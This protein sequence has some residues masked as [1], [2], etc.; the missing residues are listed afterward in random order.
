VVSRKVNGVRCEWWL[1]AISIAASTLLMLPVLIA[2]HYGLFSDAGQLIEFPRQV[3]SDWPQ[4]I[5]LFK[6]LPDGR[7]NPLFHGLSVAL[8]VISPENPLV[9]F[10][11]QHF[12]LSVILFG[13]SYMTLVLTDRLL[14]AIS[15]VFV[16]SI[17]SSLFENFFTLDKVEPRVSFFLIIS[18]V[19]LWLILNQRV[20]V[21]YLAATAMM[22][23]MM[24]FSKETGVFMV[25]SMAVMAAASFVLPAFKAFRLRLC[26]VFVSYL[27]PFLAYYALFKYLSVDV[28]YRYV[29]YDKSISLVLQNASFYMK[30]SP[31]LA[32]GAVSAAL[33][34][35]LRLW[36]SREPASPP[37]VMMAALS[38]SLF[39][40][41]SGILLWR[42]PLEYYLLPAHVISSIILP[43][44][45]CGIAG[46][47]RPGK[48]WKIV[49]VAITAS[50]WLTAMS[51][52]GA[53]AVA[54]YSFDEAKDKLAVLLSR[55]EFRDRRLIVPF[56]QPD[57]AE[58][59]ERLQFFIDRAR[60]DSSPVELF[61]MW[62]PP[63]DKLLNLNRF[64][65]SAGLT[66]TE[67]Q[68]RRVSEIPDRTVIWKFGT[69]GR[70]TTMEQIEGGPESANSMWRYSTLQKGDLLLVPTGSRALRRFSARGLAAHMKTIEDFQLS[71]PVATNV[72]A[73]VSTGIGP[74]KI[75]WNI[76]EV[77]ED[78]AQSDQQRQLVAKL[79]RLNRQDDLTDDEKRN[80][81]FKKQMLPPDSVFFGD[82]W[83]EPEVSTHE[84]FRWMG[85]QASLWITPS[86][87]GICKF[88]MMVEPLVTS[89]GDKL[90]LAAK[91]GVVT[92]DVIQD[93][94]EVSV[95]I[96]AVAAQTTEIR[97]SA[98]GG[99]EAPPPGD[100][101][102]LKL[103]VFA[104]G[105]LNCSR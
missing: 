30:T 95:S 10:I 39:A 19:F 65:G 55:P 35:A 24:I 105:T 70:D 90:T 2:P 101:R 3:V 67:G 62:E 15:S 94:T 21:M 54:I 29:S 80:A 61:N 78:E 34:L 64:E 14:F 11:F 1:L 89:A 92:P 45:V 86:S 87:S 100:T 22:S 84:M 38:M 79:R 99:L 4:S 28:D 69:D 104:V 98:V 9:F 43:V 16:F 77:T 74:I 47:W 27:I 85:A 88:S 82:G 26:L 13:I 18:L 48:A 91:E 76:L 57:S 66:P 53:A 52:R 31:E 7:W 71:T 46:Q 59:G 63:S 68:L 8:Y 6:P 41:I 93:R 40:Y 51:Q 44:V 50:L 75:A 25:A 103:R 20:R 58:F 17:S 102:L 60:H 97:L 56:E 36:K 83:Y 23:A 37:E 81:F 72:L 32:I 96:D 33:I 12:M 73:T 49:L 42:W 5:A